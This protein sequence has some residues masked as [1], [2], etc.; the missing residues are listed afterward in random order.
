MPKDQ[1]KHRH[2][3][4]RSGNNRLGGN[5]L[6]RRDGFRNHVIQLHKSFSCNN[7][8]QQASIRFI[9][10]THQVYNL[11][12]NIT[13]I[14]RLTQR[15]AHWVQDTVLKVREPATKPFINLRRDFGSTPQGLFTTNRIR[16]R[17]MLVVFASSMPMLFE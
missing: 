13:S 4:S 17:T 15:R 6:G 3:L 9:M 7:L 14:A 2:K 11:V 12:L 1:A 10:E 8:Y 5:Y 16:S